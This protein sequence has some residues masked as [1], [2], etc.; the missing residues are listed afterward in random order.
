[1]IRPA[2]TT[3]HVLAASASPLAV[4]IRRG[5]SKWWHFL[6]WNRET[7]VIEPG[8]WFRG[9][10]YPARCDVAPRGDAMVLLALRGSGIPVAWTALC[11]PPFV[12]AL[13]FW[14]QDSVRLGGGFFDGRLPVA[15][16]NL[17]ADTIIPEVHE[18]TPYEFGYQEEEGQVFGSFA[19]KMHRDGWKPDPDGVAGRWILASPDR[20]RDLLLDLAAS[21][22]SEPDPTA[23]AV[24]GAGLYSLR[25]G[26]TVHP[27]PSVQWAC[28]NRKGL[29]SMAAGGLLQS[30]AA[31]EDLRVMTSIDLRPLKPGFRRQMPL[32]RTSAGATAS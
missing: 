16:L 29:L 24:E 10:V 14:P 27:L 25:Q 31:G 20:S 12:R 26:A 18:R 6:L 11:R 2:H 5:P 19:E 21:T 23:P 7:G 9:M 3:L 13:A 8:S 22:D 1:M 17:T 15:W 30:A 32:R 28:W 4:V